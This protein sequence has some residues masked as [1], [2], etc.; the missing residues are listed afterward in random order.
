[1]KLRLR[2]VGAKKQPAYRI[3]AA[4]SRAPRD[5]RFIEIIGSYNPLTDPATVHVDDERALYWLR[6]G[7]QPTDIIKKLFTKQGTWAKFTG[8]AVPDPV[9]EEAP[10]AVVDEATPVVAEEA[11]PAI[12]ITEPV[13]PVAEAAAVEEA[14]ASAEAPFAEEPPVV[15]AE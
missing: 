2:R 15:E 13:T 12:E 6:T 1:V 4:D 11:A 8:E 7:A 5:G 9:V 10:P 3:V 14:P